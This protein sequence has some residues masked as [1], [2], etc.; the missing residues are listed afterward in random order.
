MIYFIKETHALPDFP[1]IEL[2]IRKKKMLYLQQTL[3]FISHFISLN[4]RINFS[5]YLKKINLLNKGNELFVCLQ[6]ENLCHQLQSAT[7]DK[8]RRVVVHALKDVS[9]VSIKKKIQF[10]NI[11]LYEKLIEI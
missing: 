3:L 8:D 9:E 6:I 2:M 1:V 10:S 7:S 11:F 5:F 4:K